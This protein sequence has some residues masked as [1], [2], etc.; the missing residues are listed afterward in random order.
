MKQDCIFCTPPSPPVIEWDLSYAIFDNFPVSPGHVLIIPKRHEADYFILEE[1]EKNDLWKM[2]DK[3]RNLLNE[4]YHPD[5]FNVGIKID[6]A[7]GQ[8]IFHV[9]IH[10]IPRH[11]G[12]VEDPEGGVRG[13]IAGKQKY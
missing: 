3:V 11:I 1:H 6:H 12:D 7:T 4:K 10:V 2:V 8:T 9:H 5:G 13:V